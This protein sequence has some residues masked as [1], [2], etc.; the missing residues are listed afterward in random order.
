MVHLVLERS[1][2]ARCA[3]DP[4]WLIVIG[5]RPIVIPRHTADRNDRKDESVCRLS[6]GNERTCE[7]NGE[8]IAG[9]HANRGERRVSRNACTPSMTIP[10]SKRERFCVS[11][12]PTTCVYVCT[13]PCI[14]DARAARKATHPRCEPTAG[15]SVPWMLLSL[16]VVD[17]SHQGCLRSSLVVRRRRV[18]RVSSHVVGEA[19]LRSASLSLSLSLSPLQ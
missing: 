11:R 19:P 1:A 17:V 6:G 16:V 5:C 8:D 7:D 10:D 13:Y 14:R 2:T 12:M 15:F 4:R 3:D 18:R 9:G